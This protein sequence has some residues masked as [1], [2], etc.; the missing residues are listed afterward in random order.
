METSHSDNHTDRS[1]MSFTENM[2]NAF[3]CF[4][5][6][7]LAEGFKNIT[8]TG[9]RFIKTGY[10]FLGT[11]S[12]MDI[13][14]N[15]KLRWDQKILPTIGNVLGTAAML[16]AGTVAIAAVAGASVL[17]PPFLFAASCVGVF[18][19]TTHYLDARKD[20]NILR[21][22]LINSKKFQEFILKKIPQENHSTVL[23]YTY[24]PQEI[25]KKFYDLRNHINDSVLPLA[26]KEKLIVALYQDMQ[27][28]A[29]G[30]PCQLTINDSNLPKNIQTLKSDLSMLWQ[31]HD[32]ARNEVRNLN[33]SKSTQHQIDAFKITQE[34]IW[35]QDLPS[36]IK[37]NL[38]LL[39]ENKKNKKRQI[40]DLYLRMGNDYLNRHPI[41]Q[42]E[43][44]NKQLEKILIKASVSD[45]D[46]LTVMSYLKEPREIYDTLMIFKD[47]LKNS[48][49]GN[50]IEYY[51][52]FPSAATAK[53][54]LIYL[55]NLHDQTILSSD[56]FKK[57]KTQVQ[58]YE[59][60][61][62]KYE[63]F[64]SQLPLEQKLIRSIENHHFQG[65]HQY[66]SGHQRVNISPHIT[67]PVEEHDVVTQSN[68]KIKSGIK[69]QWRAFRR[70]AKNEPALNPL[71]ADAETPKK[72][73]SLKKDF[74]RENEYTFELIA[75]AEKLAFLEKAVPRYMANIF[76][77]V[78]VA[79]LSLV[80]TF[81]IPAVASPAAPAAIAAGAA[82]TA[83]S[84]GLTVAS[85]SNTADLMR[86]DFKQQYKVNTTKSDISSAVS[87]HIELN[88]E[89]ELFAKLK[90][91]LKSSSPKQKQAASAAKED[92]E[93]PLPINLSTL[94][95]N[96]KNMHFT[97][98]ETT[99][100]DREGE[101]TGREKKDNLKF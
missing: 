48:A 21:K 15:K 93:L 62:E 5:E 53:D 9:G 55:E 98:S 101:K 19:H 22:E 54:A 16:M 31:T 18:K 30:K 20:R 84:A 79:T 90:D 74:Q 51:L 50:L 29:N 43:H 87:P 40:A 94:K 49:K 77:S 14:N 56:N 44:Q 91:E 45:N 81:V 86:T 60:T 68:K 38:T 99:S 34:K 89:A 10:T 26:E 8:H 100:S 63:Q 23:K 88:H 42:V 3:T 36:S 4:S 2:K 39:I 33:L 76:L 66:A 96:K 13:I 37:E 1:S 28:F 32:L 52:N 64:K 6:L 59:A 85:I 69:K 27:N 25:Y 57:L 24:L 41:E 83:L 97:D 61:S 46:R 72:K 70:Q 11:Y 47:H 75:E 73:R 95:T 17:L 65:L 92:I 35:C 67:I 58:K 71:V 82:V 78:G 80:T 7:N 12:V